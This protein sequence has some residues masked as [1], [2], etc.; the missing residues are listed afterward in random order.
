ML[1]SNGEVVTV[2]QH[3]EQS[4]RGNVNL[5]GSVHNGGIR[6]RHALAHTP[7]H[8]AKHLLQVLHFLSIQLVLP[9]RMRLCLFFVLAV[10]E[11]NPPAAKR[12]LASTKM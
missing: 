1:R 7:L 3:L 10:D 8:L 5:L 11:A 9:W 2:L 4:E 6:R 12:V